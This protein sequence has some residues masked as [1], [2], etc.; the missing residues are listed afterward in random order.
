MALI[1]IQHSLLDKTGLAKDRY[2]NTIYAL[3]KS[4][5]PS[6]HSGLADAFHAFFHALAG[7]LSPQVSGTGAE[8]RMYDMHDAKPR[9]PIYQHT[10]AGEATS[11]QTA[12]LPAEVALCLT[13]HGMPVASPVKPQSWRGRIYVGPLASSA[14]SDAS[15]PNLQSRPKAAFASAV[16]AAA[17]A[18][19]TAIDTADA[20]W[21]IFSERQLFAYPVVNVSTDDAWDTQRSRGDRPTVATRVAAGGAGG[22]GTDVTNLVSV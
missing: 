17:V 3:D 20:T 9:I 1:R 19:S 2:V 11:G 22:H 10:Y 14:L 7:Y 6:V 8:V 21:V 15:E 4:V 13:F 12:A 5:L 18:M 16:N